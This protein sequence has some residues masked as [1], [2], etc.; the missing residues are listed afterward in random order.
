[1]PCDA[2]RK[3]FLVVQL[4][5]SFSVFYI[6]VES[7]L[8]VITFCIIC[9]RSTINA[10]VTHF[11]LTASSENCCRP[12]IFT[13][14]CKWNTPPCGRPIRCK[15]NPYGHINSLQAIRLAERLGNGPW[16]VGG[17]QAGEADL[18]SMNAQW[19]PLEFSAGGG[20]SGA[21]D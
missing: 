12:W 4:L 5:Q 8:A 10:D 19:Q 1:M 11:L 21:W 14:L 16:S 17:D 20:S 2:Y 13:R 18:Y 15:P 6:C 3:Q 7:R 9:S